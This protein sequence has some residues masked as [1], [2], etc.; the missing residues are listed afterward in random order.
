MGKWEK[1]KRALRLNVCLPYGKLIWINEWVKRYLYIIQNNETAKE[2]E[3]TAKTVLK[4][5]QGGCAGS[6]NSFMHLTAATDPTGWVVWTKILRGIAHGSMCPWVQFLVKSLFLA[7]NSRF[8]IVSSLGLSSTCQQR[9]KL[10]CLFFQLE[11]YQSFG[12]R[13]PPLWVDCQKMLSPKRARGL[14]DHPDA[15]ST[16]RGPFSTSLR[17][18]LQNSGSVENSTRPIYEEGLPRLISGQAPFLSL[19]KLTKSSSWPACCLMNESP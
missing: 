5:C 13:V 3:D 12:I 17:L 18:T 9:S 10:G 4:D 16:Q 8:L 15:N 2:P 19:L 7:A 6:G 1:G 11:G 14:P